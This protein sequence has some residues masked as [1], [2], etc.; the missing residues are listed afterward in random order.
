MGPR[1]NA[2]CCGSTGESTN[3][4]PAFPYA[5]TAAGVDYGLPPKNSEAAQEADHDDKENAG[6]KHRQTAK[7][8]RPSTTVFGNIATKLWLPS[9]ERLP[10]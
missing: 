4:P 3:G 5:G 10:G 8:K 7:T 6:K 9:D 2:E 1:H